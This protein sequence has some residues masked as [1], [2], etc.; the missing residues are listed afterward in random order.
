M[1]EQGTPGQTQ[2]QKE[3]IQRVQVRTDS[4]GRIQFLPRKGI[5]GD[6]FLRY[7]ENICGNI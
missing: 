2:T 7:L 4:L 1:N 5:W 3:N 6:G